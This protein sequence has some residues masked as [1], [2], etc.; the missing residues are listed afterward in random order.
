MAANRLV[1]VA[2]HDVEMDVRHGLP[3]RHAVELGDDHAVRLEGL[4]H[5]TRHA[6]RGLDRRRRAGLGQAEQ[7]HCLL[8]RHDQRVAVGLRHD[9]HERDGV[10]VLVDLEAREFATQDAGEDVLVVVL[11]LHGC[12]GKKKP[13]SRRAMGAV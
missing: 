13:A 6:L 5:G 9:V 1:R 10:R 2:R 3:R 7:V 12:L 11:G 8:L 4:A